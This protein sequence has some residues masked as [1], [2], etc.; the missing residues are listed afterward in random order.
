[1][2]KKKGIFKNV[3]VVSAIE[4]AFMLLGVVAASYLYSVIMMHLH[5][6]SGVAA[7]FLSEGLYWYLFTLT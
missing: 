2:E 1:M 3:I 4:L 7:E 5:F 6:N